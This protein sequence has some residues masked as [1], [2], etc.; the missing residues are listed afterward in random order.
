MPVTVMPGVRTLT[1]P[2]GTRV[3]A[4]RAKEVTLRLATLD[5]APEVERYFSWMRFGMNWDGI[6]DE[7]TVNHDG[8]VLRDP[9]LD[10][11]YIQRVWCSEPNA[12][13]RLRVKQSDGKARTWTVA[14]PRAADAMLVDWPCVRRDAGAL[15]VEM[16]THGRNMPVVVVSGIAVGENPELREPAR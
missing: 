16:I 8:F 3:V 2:D 10:A 12:G 14:G 9:E 6:P 15:I 5:W 11:W 1:L 13:V 4:D 7:L